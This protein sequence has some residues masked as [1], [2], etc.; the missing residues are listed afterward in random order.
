M[1]ECVKARK[2]LLAGQ[3]VKKM[4]MMLQL[5][6]LLMKEKLERTPTLKLRKRKVR[7]P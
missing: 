4:E 6:K 5:R 7:H 3:C 1:T 2:K